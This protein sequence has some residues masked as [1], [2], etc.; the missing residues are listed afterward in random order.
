MFEMKATW[1]GVTIAGI[2][3]LN[4][5]QTGYDNGIYR[6]VD[7]VICHQAEVDALVETQAER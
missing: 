1:N 2:P 6:N 3:S 7:P 4:W 5:V